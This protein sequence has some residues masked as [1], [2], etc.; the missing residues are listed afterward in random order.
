MLN[1]LSL[2]CLFDSEYTDLAGDRR[3]KD[4]SRFGIDPRV[5]DGS[6][7]ATFPTWSAQDGRYDFDGGDYML[8]TTA[9]DSDDVLALM[10]SIQPETYLFYFDP[11]VI[12]GNEQ[13]LFGWNTGSGTD[14]GYIRINAGNT[15]TL[16]LDDDVGGMEELTSGSILEWNGHSVIVAVVRDPT[17]AVRQLMYLNAVEF[18]TDTDVAVAGASAVA[19]Y[20]GRN[21]AGGSLLQVGT[22]LRFFGYS[23]TAF[24]QLQLQAIQRYLR[25]FL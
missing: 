19:K 6:T 18:A 9:Y 5:G 20:I 1:A 2:A 24:A 15:L 22:G 17:A 21:T 12:D 3:T 14:R 13:Y 10:G 23:A 8:I 7:P 16:H 11:L 4:R 25:G